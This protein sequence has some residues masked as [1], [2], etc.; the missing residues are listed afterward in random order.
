MCGLCGVV[1]AAGPVDREV[2]G[3]MTGTLRPRGPDDAAYYVPET[4][5]ADAAVGF[6]FRRLSIIDVEG[7]RQPLGN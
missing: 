5:G 1:D 6:G 3:R 4:D 2:L 7:G